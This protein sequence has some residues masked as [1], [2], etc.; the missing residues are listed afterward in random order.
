[1]LTGRVSIVK[2]NSVS[3]VAGQFEEVIVVQSSIDNGECTI[4]SYEVH[5]ICALCDKG[6]YRWV[7]PEDIHNI[8]DSPNLCKRSDC[9]SSD[10][11]DSQD[12]LQ[13]TQSVDELIQ[14]PIIN[15][16]IATSS[17]GTSSIAVVKD[18]KG[19][20]KSYNIEGISADD[21]LLIHGSVPYLELTNYG[22]MEAPYHP[23]RILGRL[24]ST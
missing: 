2:E 4:V 15:Y 16:G 5:A 19:E 12:N 14:C 21:S 10:G 22:D 1:M 17:V 8:H 11:H 20:I 24:V 9:V 6:F 18:H 23:I 13:S 7:L 3:N